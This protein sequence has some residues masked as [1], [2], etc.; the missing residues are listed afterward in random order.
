MAI[1]LH[2]LLAD[3]QM[4]QS[5]HQMDFFVTIRLGATPYGQ[6]KQALRE[7]FKRYRGLK[8]LLPAR[9]LLAL[10]IEELEAKTRRVFQRA[11]TRHRRR[12]ELTKLRMGLE[13]LDRNIHET[14]RGFDHFQAQASALR[15][16]LVPE[17]ELT[18]E[19][20]ARLDRE[21]WHHKIRA[22]AA[23]DLVTT[24]GL[25]ENTVTFLQASPPEWRKP[26]LKEVKAE[27][28][29]SHSG[30]EIEKGLVDWFMEYDSPLPALP[31]PASDEDAA[32]L[33]ER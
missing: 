28:V 25:R 11:R 16:V 26:L 10:D 4:Y 19:L 33:L 7:V 1:G 18:P 15:A 13:D 30:E 5:D 23:V 32:A 27:M 21:M 12:I 9:D 31:E 17:G 2:A 8:E 14:Q 22:M 29:A 24:G 20:R 6:Y 3:H